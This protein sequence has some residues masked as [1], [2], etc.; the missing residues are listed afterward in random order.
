MLQ[1]KILNI[2][3]PNANLNVDINVKKKSKTIENNYCTSTKESPSIYCVDYSSL[4]DIY[5]IITPIKKFE[6]GGEYNLNKGF[7]INPNVTNYDQTNDRPYSNLPKNPSTGIIWHSHPFD[8]PNDYPSIE[9]LDS[10]RLSPHIV[11]IILC[12]EGVYVMSS[13]QPYIPLQSLISFYND[14][15][16]TSKKCEWNPQ[17]LQHSF[18]HNKQF[19]SEFLNKYNLFVSFIP[20]IHISEKLLNLKII[21]AFTYKNPSLLIPYILN[22]IQIFKSKILI[23]P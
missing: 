2:K 3:F 23:S 8:Y 20:K 18:T 6:L 14:M 21:D 9:D 12:K 10:L 7:L 22:E 16:P 13:L 11:S 17:E 5:K 1:S 4:F 15:Q 19:T